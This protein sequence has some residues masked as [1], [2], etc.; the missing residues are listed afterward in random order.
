MGPTLEVAQ[1]CTRWRHQACR[2]GGPQHFK[3]GEKVKSGPQLGLAVQGLQPEQSGHPRVTIELSKR[4]A[5]NCFNCGRSGHWSQDCPI[6]SKGQG[7][8]K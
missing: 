8:D 6:L 2:L 4:E 7:G 1:K 3:A 5:L